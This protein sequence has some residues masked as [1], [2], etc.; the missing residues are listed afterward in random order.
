MIIGGNHKEWP[1]EDYFKQYHGGD[2]Y[3]DT[4]DDIRE[5]FMQEYEDWL[6]EQ[7]LEEGPP[8]DD[9]LTWVKRK[10]WIVGV[11]WARDNISD[12]WFKIDQSVPKRPEDKERWFMAPF[13]K[14]SRKALAQL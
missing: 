13:V 8:Q 11:Q 7:V 14:E 6:W 2:G 1:G 3:D 10:A 12:G 9:D 5:G 4:Y